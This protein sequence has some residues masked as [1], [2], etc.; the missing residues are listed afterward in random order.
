MAVSLKN[1]GSQ[2]SWDPPAKVTL[3][4]GLSGLDMRLKGKTCT[5]H[6]QMTSPEAGGFH[7]P[8]LAMTL[9]L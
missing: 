5:G 8:F 9:W 1:E 6:N 7:P 2:L 3:W 4:A